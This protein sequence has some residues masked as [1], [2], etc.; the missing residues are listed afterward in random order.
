MW[1]SRP[2]IGVGREKKCISLLILW[3]LHGPICMNVAIACGWSSRFFQ[4]KPEMWRK[5][6]AFSV[7]LP[8]QG[9]IE[10]LTHTMLNGVLSVKWP[11]LQMKNTIKKLGIL[12]YA[13]NDNH[14]IKRINLVQLYNKITIQKKYFLWFVMIWC[15][16]LHFIF[17]LAICNVIG[18][19]DI[20]LASKLT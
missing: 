12:K 5:K 6:K 4:R 11:E 2:P 8:S 16:N 3:G 13:S 9:V 15:T 7:F 1:I 18:F 14:N 10:I 17:Y 20:N 19:G